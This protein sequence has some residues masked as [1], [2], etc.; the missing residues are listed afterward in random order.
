MRNA[1]ATH[2]FWREFGQRLSVRFANIDRFRRAEAVVSKSLSQLYRK[3]S[4]SSESSTDFNTE[5]IHIQHGNFE[6]HF[7][8]FYIQFFEFHFFFEYRTHTIVRNGN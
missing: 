3:Q 1:S 8:V 4:E 2:Q 6:Q 7:I 5:R